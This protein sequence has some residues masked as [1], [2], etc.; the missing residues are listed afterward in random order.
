ML[1]LTHE[2]PAFTVSDTNHI[3]CMTYLFHYQV[4]KKAF[5]IKT[6][7]L[8]LS[9]NM[10]LSNITFSEKKLTIKKVGPNSILQIL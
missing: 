9:V 6:F 1:N 4:V 7:S 8:T 5:E 2:V 10:N 3:F